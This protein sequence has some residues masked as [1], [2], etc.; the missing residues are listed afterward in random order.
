MREV[1]TGVWHWEARHPEWNERQWWGPEVS[2]YAVD[3]GTRLVLFDPL[4]PPAEVDAL[5]GAR[6]T[7]IVL[8][9]PWHRRGSLALAEQYGCPLFVPPPDPHDPDP[10]DGTVYRAGDRLPVGVQ[11]L[12]GMEPIDLVLWVE[13]HRVLVSGDTLQDRGEGL[14]F[15][16]DLE[17][18]VPGDIDVDAIRARLRASLLDL[19]VELV[20]PTHGPPADRAD[21]ETALSPPP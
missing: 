6:E 16:G 17:N 9:C 11:A 3:D 1:R 14:R 7:A 15:V 20:L 18:N 5:A 13:S 19:P 21:L 2:C 12:A 4:E 8:T 10:P